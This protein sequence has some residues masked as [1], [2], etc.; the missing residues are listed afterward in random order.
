MMSLMTDSPEHTSHPAPTQQKPYWLYRFAAWVVIVAGIV[1]IVSTIFFTG[2]YVGRGGHQHHCHHSMSH[3]EG[4]GPAMPEDAH[5]GPG[6]APAS[7]AP[8]R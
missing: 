6:E 7:V 2:A 4:A 1:F 8:G 3:H 5:P